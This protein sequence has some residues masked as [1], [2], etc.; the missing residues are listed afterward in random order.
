[1]SEGLGR[2]AVRGVAWLG[3]GQ[4]IRQ[5]IGLL[6][7]AVLARL[8][9]PDDFGLFG[10]SYMAAELAQLL[11][12]FGFGAAI[13]QRQVESPSI[14]TSAFWANILLGLVIAGVLVACGPLLALYFRRDEVAHLMWP[15]ALNM[16]VA[17]AVVVPQA[18]LTQRMHFVSIT[19]AQ[20]VGSV[21]AAVAAVSAAY[22]GAGYWSLAIQPMVGGI[23][24]GLMMVRASRW[25]PR[26][27][28]AFEHIREMLGF[29][30]NLM[31]SHVVGWAG[32]NMAG[33]VLGR[34]LG[35]AQVAVYG[36][37]SGITGAVL[38]QISS[39]IVRVLFPTLSVLKDEPQ[40]LH[41]AWSQSCAG[42]AVVAFPLL[43]VIIGVA[44]DFVMVVL[45]SQW[46]EAAD[47][48]RWLS[49]AMAFQAVLTTSSTMLMAMGRTDW[50]LRLSVVTTLALFGGLWLGSQFGVTESAL[51]YSLISTASY[52]MTTT[53]AC[54]VCG[55][56][57]RRLLGSLLPWAAS[58]C[59]AGLVAQCG[60]WLLPDWLPL[61]RLLVCSLAGGVA[62]L[63]MLALVARDRTTSLINSI[64][65][66]LRR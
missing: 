54:R 40:R 51:A 65:K 10:M 17:A 27:R 41:N 37:A 26:G 18:I 43:A 28:P 42:I 47:P 44:D 13:V 53:L 22:L 3:G 19:Q 9:T 6:T 49:A 62:Y 35:A 8:L 39:V 33:M 16:V 32:R 36:L 45:G 56:P 48:L 31:G 61:P 64:W 57:L 5:V 21:C 7:T 24:T 34:Q 12:A 2:Q 14:L 20:A 58:A 50:L 55:L 66:N 1:M 25:T 29:S 60:V 30:T 52:L 11:T 63:A 15:L 23:V 4:L 38:T 59:V 46:T